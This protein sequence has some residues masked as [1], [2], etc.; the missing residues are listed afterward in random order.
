[1]IGPGYV[2]LFFVPGLK[3]M[4]VVCARRRSKVG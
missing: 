1:M 3:W 4:I 2:E